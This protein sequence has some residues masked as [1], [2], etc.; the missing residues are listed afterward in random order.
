MN[1]MAVNLMLK[2]MVSKKVLLLTNKTPLLIVISF[3]V[4]N[5]SRNV[6]IFS[7]HWI[8][9]FVGGIELQQ[10]DVGSIDCLIYWLLYYNNT[11]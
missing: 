4:H 7:Y 1:K 3:W 9:I 11:E 6:Y 2:L 5:L 10:G 8:W